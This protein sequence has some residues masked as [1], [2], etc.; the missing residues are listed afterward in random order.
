MRIIKGGKIGKMKSVKVYRLGRKG[1]A[2]AE[3]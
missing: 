2:E 3:R 1:K